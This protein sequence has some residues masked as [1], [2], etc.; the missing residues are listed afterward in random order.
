MAA[1]YDAPQPVAVA[2]PVARAM[3]PATFTVQYCICSC[4]TTA[5]AVAS[6]SWDCRQ[7]AQ[8]AFCW[9]NE[10]Q[11]AAEIGGVRHES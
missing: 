7:G 4:H 6:V 9:T 10:L 11:V 8:F 1:A 5:A 2:S 3:Q